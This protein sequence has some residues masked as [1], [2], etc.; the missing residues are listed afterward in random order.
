MITILNIIFYNNKYIHC[1]VICLC[2]GYQPV[3]SSPFLHNHAEEKKRRAC[4]TGHFDC[5]W[6]SRASSITTSGL[7]KGLISDFMAMRGTFALVSLVVCCFY[8]G[9]LGSL[10]IELSSCFIN[11]NKLY[12][13]IRGRSAEELNKKKKNY[14]YLC[15]RTA[16]QWVILRG[17]RLG[18]LF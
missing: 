17:K 7:F 4:L 6:A 13:W 10:Y 12:T 18:R 15:Q 16:G 2:F 3:L 8:F 1:Y 9:T 14:M 5:L 11:K